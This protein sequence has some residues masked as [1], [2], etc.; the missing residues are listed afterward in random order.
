MYQQIIDINK[1]CAVN[2]GQN[3]HAGTIRFI[4]KIHDVERIGVELDEE[5]GKNDGSAFGKYY[6]KCKPK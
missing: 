6:F 2:I 4:G 3:T 1:R 5:V